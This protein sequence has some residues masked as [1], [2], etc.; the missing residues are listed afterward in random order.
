MAQYGKGWFRGNAPI[1]DFVV[2]ASAPPDTTAVRYLYLG[3]GDLT[4][5]DVSESSGLRNSGAQVNDVAVADFDNDGD[6]DLYLA[7]GVDVANQPDAIYLNDGDG[8]FSPAG[9]RLEVPLEYR[10]SADLVATADFD[11]DGRLEIVVHNGGGIDPF[12][13]PVNLLRTE[14][15]SGHWLQVD[16]RPV[17]GGPTALGTRVALYAGGRVQVR[18]WD[19]GQGNRSQDEAILH[20]GLGDADVVERVEIEWPDGTVRSL[21]DVQVDTRIRVPVDW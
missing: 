17:M 13:G 2:E 20:F 9:T 18:H 4:F 5:R 1:T 15:G 11:I 19:Q 16:L 10:G 8:H 14:G 3:N 6:L 7:N 21:T 12:T